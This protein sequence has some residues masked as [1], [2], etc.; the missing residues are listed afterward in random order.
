M[1]LQTLAAEVNLSGQF[2]LKE[3]IL[4]TESLWFTMQQLEGQK[5]PKEKGIIQSQHKTE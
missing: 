3:Q 1:S 2:I 4:T 5:F